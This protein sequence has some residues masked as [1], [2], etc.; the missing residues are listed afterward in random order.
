MDVVFSGPYH[1]FFADDSKVVLI[2]D[3][4]YWGQDASMFGKLPT[5]EVPGARDL[6]R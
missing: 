5:P 3:D 4:K 6:Q 2:R 1:Y